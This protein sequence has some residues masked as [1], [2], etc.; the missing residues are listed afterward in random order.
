[1]KARTECLFFLPFL[2]IFVNHEWNT[3]A[4]IKLH[5]NT[6][7]LHEKPSSQK[8]KKKGGGDNTSKRE[9]VKLLYR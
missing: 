9:Y 8:K 6:L 1:M 2:K 7:K 5:Y 4:E 3:P